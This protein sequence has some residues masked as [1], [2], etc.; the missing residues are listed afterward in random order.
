MTLSTNSPEQ[1]MGRASASPAA[2][3]LAAGLRGYQAWASPIF[4]A[5]GSRCCFEP[6]CSQYALEAVQTRGAL[7]GALL[8]LWRLLRCNPLSEGGY[9]PLKQSVGADEQRRRG[10]RRLA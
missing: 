8:A 4:A 5:L 6:S 7:R 1:P 10:M 2:R 9:D 3:L